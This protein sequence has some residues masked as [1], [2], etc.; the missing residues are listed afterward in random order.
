MREGDLRTSRAILMRV[1]FP[2]FWMVICVR[3]YTYLVIRVTRLSITSK[4][5]KS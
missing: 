4:I 2:D 3:R 1:I 5:N